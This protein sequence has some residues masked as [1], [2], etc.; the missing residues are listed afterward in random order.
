MLIWF[1]EGF[2]PGLTVRIRP[3]NWPNGEA[4]RGRAY[5]GFR[6]P[7]AE[8]GHFPRS[9]HRSMCEELKRY[10]DFLVSLGNRKR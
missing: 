1:L 8:P 5:P 2:R 4:A 7:L 10:T 6:R 9:K 3:Q